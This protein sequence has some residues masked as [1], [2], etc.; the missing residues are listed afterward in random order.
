MFQKE[1]NCFKYLFYFAL[2]LALSNQQA[3]AK[4][5]LTFG[6]SSVEENDDRLRPGIYL[7]FS[8]DDISSA[9]YHYGRKF[10]PFVEKTYFLG[11]GQ[12]F[13][14]PGL[15]QFHAILGLALMR[16][17]TTLKF[18]GADTVFDREECRYN[19]GVF[20]GLSF[21]EDIMNSWF[22]E[23]SWNSGVFAAGIAGG[24]FLATGRKQ[25]V[26]LALGHSW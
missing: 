23:A 21:R 22:F 10:G 19:G 17:D 5:E 1:N 11:I 16:E 2:L 26:S 4:R 8:K 20:L 15:K 25:F 24:L 3:Q 6:I 12:K 7:G 18:R 13:L 14:F 9:L